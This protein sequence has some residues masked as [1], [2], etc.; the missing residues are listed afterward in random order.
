[1]KK[2]ALFLLLSS[3]L[4]LQAGADTI[5][6]RNGTALEGKVI[7]EDADSYQV[8]VQVT[9]SI[10]DQRKIPKADV[11]EI[12]AEKTDEVAFEKIKDLVPTPD[13]LDTA[14][15]DKRVEAVEKF[16]SDHSGSKLL[17]EAG[18]MLKV[19]DA[20]RKTVAEGG[21]KFDGAMI[22]PEDHRTQAYPIDSRIAAERV[23]RQ[24][25]SGDLVGALRAWDALEKEFGSSKAYIETIPYALK[26]M[27]T[28]LATVNRD[29]S[30]F[31]DRVKKRNDGI[32]RIDA[33]D[34]PR[35]ERAIA[36]ETAAYLRRVDSEKKATLRWLSL[37]PFEKGPM[38]D[39]KRLLESEIKRLSS[40]DPSKVPDGDAAWTEAWKVLS[41]TP[42]PQEATA[43]ISAANSARLPKA[44]IDLLSAKAPAR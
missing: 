27:R 20:E 33:S 34:R 17:K 2:T 3:L 35:T 8:L 1:M 25:D 6:L 9:K 7:S 4:A 19:L 14:Q 10:R 36:D 12:V 16:M 43:A 37:H 5:R 42:T 21:V 30:S 39:A 40:L 18:A 29:L 13:L 38:D 11:L 31:D 44:Y 15:Y 22:E 26:L 23:R 32:E 28:Q 41:G 24:G